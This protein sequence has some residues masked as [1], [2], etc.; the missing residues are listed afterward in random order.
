MSDSASIMVIAMF[1]MQ[2]Y[3]CVLIMQELYTSRLP[4]SCSTV[5]AD[6]GPMPGTPVHSIVI[7]NTYK[8]NSVRCSVILCTNTCSTLERLMH[9]AQLLV[10]THTRSAVIAIKTQWSKPTCG[11]LYVH[12]YQ[13]GLCVGFSVYTAV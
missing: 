7:H 12:A 11:A 3:D 5:A 6:L 8:I 2:S 4:C 1:T 13:N 10:K 9:A